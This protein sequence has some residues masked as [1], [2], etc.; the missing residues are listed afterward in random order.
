MSENEI[1]MVYG[2]RCRCKEG[3]YYLT[4]GFGRLV[5]EM[6]K[7][8]ERVYLMIPVIHVSLDEVF[9]EYALEGSNI[10]VQELTPYSG[11]IEAIKKTIQLKKQIKEYSMQWKGVVY[12]RWMTALYE[13]IYKCAKRKNLQVCFHLVDDGETIIKDGNKY[14]GIKRFFALCVAKKNSKIIKKIMKTVPTLINGNG[15]RRLY[16]QDN[17]HVK[18]IRTS[19][20]LKSEITH[21]HKT[22]NKDKV[23]LIF[24]GT[25]RPAKGLDYLLQAMDK[26]IKYGINIYLTI[27][28]DGDYI[29]TLKERAKTMRI[30]DRIRFTGRLAMGKQLFEEYKQSDIFILPSLSE[31][32][33]R[34]L[35]EAMCNGVPVIAT[36][37]GGITFTVKDHENGLIVPTANAEAI[38]KAIVEIIEDDNLRNKVVQSGFLFAENNTI[39]S[40]TNE[41]CSF[42]R[43]YCGEGV[44]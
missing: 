19:T 24:V 34:T 33:P 9:S 36:D 38:V 21:N 17:D 37:A 32:T 27:V 18:E 35:I 31:G 25:V 42:I 40:H 5:D 20:F 11:Y 30:I 12:I 3:K 4:G 6:A 23:N 7:K 10:T 2:T 28:G 44:K 1:T 8:Y 14:K 41:V 39:E 13:Y 22:M 29:E 26:L 16:R 15:M 43:Q